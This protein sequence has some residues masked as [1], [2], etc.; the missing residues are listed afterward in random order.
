MQAEKGLSAAD[1][2]MPQVKEILATCFGSAQKARHVRDIIQ[3]QS[4]GVDEG[5]VTCVMQGVR[6]RARHEEW[7]LC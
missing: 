7:P 6:T 1:L 2:K 5:F 4:A 3:G